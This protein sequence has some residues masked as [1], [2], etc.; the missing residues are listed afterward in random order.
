M[1]YW[2][3]ELKGSDKS[4]AFLNDLLKSSQLSIIKDQRG[5][6][7]KITELGNETMPASLRAPTKRIIDMVNGA[8]LLLWPN[9][10]PVESN[11]IH[12][13]ADDGSRQSF[14]FLTA[15]ST[16]QIQFYV[17]DPENTMLSDWIDLADSEPMVERAFVLYG[18][19]AHDWKG[20]YMILEVVKD[21]VG[22]WDSLVAKGW[23]SKSQLSDFKHTANSFAAVGD[24]ARHA[25]K[26]I[27][28][29]NNPMSLMDAKT[30]AHSILRRWLALK[31]SAVN[32]KTA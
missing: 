20:L 25:T 7:I 16:P 3:I 26:S 23:L 15:S 9:Y 14:G 30:L 17:F 1:E 32:E 24:S 8:A 4:I 18:L 5:A 21:D 31:S 19:L 27:K 12:M 6:Y 11:M 22:S 10:E 2:L 29:P 13:V 28:A